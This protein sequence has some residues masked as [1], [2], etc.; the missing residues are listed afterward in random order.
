MVEQIKLLEGSVQHQGYKTMDDISHFKTQ[1]NHKIEDVLSALGRVSVD[2]GTTRSLLKKQTDDFAL[3]YSQ[4]E[5]NKREI[6]K[7]NKSIEE[8]PVIDDHYWTED[9]LDKFLPFRIQ[10]MIDDTIFNI[11]SYS[12]ASKLLDYEEKI[13]KQFKSNVKTKFSKL[14]KNEQYVPP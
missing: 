7:L 12:E 14:V 2:N 9:Y 11:G 8:L 13:F 6:Q 1:L 10:M 4:I 3:I 5:I